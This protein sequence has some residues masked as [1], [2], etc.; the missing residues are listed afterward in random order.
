M[1]TTLVLDKQKTLLDISE[2]YKLLT[3]T[4]S[5]LS[6]LRD[7]YPD[8]HN[9]YFNKVIPG[10]LSGERIIILKIT[11]GHISGISILKKNGNEKKICTLRVTDNFQQK[12]IGS[13]L[14]YQSCELL[15]TAKPLITVS[16]EKIK[17][18]E[19][20]FKSF[21]FK[22][23]KCYYDYYTRSKHE[24]SYN[25]FLNSNS[26][27]DISALDGIIYQNQTADVTQLEILF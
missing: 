25:G 14:L 21:D 15:D 13:E 2:S 11:N 8:F 12:G 22:L 20:L 18:F 5:V 4:Y 6:S 1:T 23:T 17:Q 10:V 7:D 24:L 26:K 9:W 27:D 19:K 3:K 16:S